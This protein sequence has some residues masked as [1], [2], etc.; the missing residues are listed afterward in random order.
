MSGY[1]QGGLDHR[2]EGLFIHRNGKGDLVAGQP[3][4]PSFEPASG[5]NCSA[6]VQERGNPLVPV[7]KQRRLDVMGL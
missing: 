4:A 5:L 3:V 2:G 6:P 1:S 7:R